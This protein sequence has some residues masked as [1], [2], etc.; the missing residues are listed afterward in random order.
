MLHH[1]VIES[2]FLGMCWIP[3][4]FSLDTLLRLHWIDDPRP[5]CQCTWLI[6]HPQP[7]WSWSFWFCLTTALVFFWMG[8]IQILWGIQLDRHLQFFLLIWAHTLLPWFQH[9]QIHLRWHISSHF[10]R[11]YFLGVCLRCVPSWIQ[12]L[13]IW[14]WC[15]SFLCLKM[16]VLIRGWRWYCWHGFS[17]FLNLLLQLL[18]YLHNPIYRLL[19]SFLLGEF[20]LSVIRYHN[21]IWN[22]LPSCFLEPCVWMNLIVLCPS[23]TLLFPFLFFPF[24]TLNSSFP[25]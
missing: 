12:V 24:P 9:T 20:L 11:L 17:L 22:S 25:H 13:L 23:P 18:C 6:N 8:S 2:W 16:L 1:N 5:L 7:R 15:I 19:L 3:N 14:S 21:R 10:I 4:K